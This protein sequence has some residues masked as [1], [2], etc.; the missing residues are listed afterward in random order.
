MEADTSLSDPTLQKEEWTT[1]EGVNA[2]ALDELEA[3]DGS[4]L[5]EGPPIAKPIVAKPAVPA[6]T[7][8]SEGATGMRPATTEAEDSSKVDPGEL[9]E[10]T[11]LVAT[12]SSPPVPMGW[13]CDG[14][15]RQMF[16]LLR[17][18]PPIPVGRTPGRFRV[19]MKRSSASQPLGIVFTRTTNGAAVV[20]EDYSHLGLRKGDLVL[21]VNGKSVTQLRQCMQVLETAL[22]VDLQLIHREEFYDSAEQCCPMMNAVA[23]S[24]EASDS[25]GDCLH[26]PPPRCQSAKW[27]L[28]DMMLTTGPLKINGNLFGVKIMRMSRKVPFGLAL[29]PE[30][31]LSTP[32]GF[33]DSSVRVNMPTGMSWKSTSIGSAAEDSPLEVDSVMAS[34]NSSRSMDEVS[35]FKSD[36]LTQRTN[37]D[38]AVHFASG[39]T[40]TADT[41]VHGFVHLAL[42]EEMAQHGLKRGDVL[43]QINGVPA[44]STTYCQAVMKGAMTLDLVFKRPEH[45]GT[46]DPVVAE[47][48]PAKEPT[49]FETNW[50][51]LSSILHFLSCMNLTETQANATAGSESIIVQTDRDP[52]GPLLMQL[53]S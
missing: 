20:A 38:S 37:K 9:M 14:E 3:L 48:L 52:T 8:T 41:N 2:K 12:E 17:S 24:C 7:P 30:P 40:T 28:R 21:S 49:D 51:S 47:E 29:C 32:K 10:P 19:F 22:E 27:P 39:S 26:P 18:T 42:R 15:D 6:S 43:L 44:H 33:S 53:N 4:V 5:I 45:V 16:S 31:L 11:T 13:G 46:I 50:P 35:D 34:R 36:L 25:C 1:S 23:Q